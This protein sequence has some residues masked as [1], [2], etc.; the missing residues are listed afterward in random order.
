MNCPSNFA[1][2]PLPWGSAEFIGLGFSVFL[3]IIICERF[4]APIMKSTSVVL[5]L[6]VGCI[7]AAAT[8]YFDRSSIDAA[9]AASFIVCQIFLNCSKFRIKFF[10]AVDL[11]S[12]GIS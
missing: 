1:P 12:K 2:H 10:K 5:G 6:L 9:P 7:I 4:G 3:T 11:L 8:G